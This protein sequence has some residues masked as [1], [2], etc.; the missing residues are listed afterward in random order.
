M[1]GIS[2]VYLWGAYDL[3]HVVRNKLLEFSALN[4][5]HKH[6]ISSGVEVLTKIHLIRW[7][8]AFWNLTAFPYMYG[9]AGMAHW[10]SL[11]RLSIATFL[12]IKTRKMKSVGK[13]SEF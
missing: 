4:S 11:S 7:T 2:K 12:V 1:W 9:W 10:E 5:D 8:S 3:S 13:Q 6:S